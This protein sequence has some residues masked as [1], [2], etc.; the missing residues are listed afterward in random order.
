MNKFILSYLKFILLV[1]DLG[2]HGKTNANIFQIKKYKTSGSHKL[3][4]SFKHDII[5]Y[6]VHTLC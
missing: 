2:A 4:K 6:L 5:V 1:G 3:T